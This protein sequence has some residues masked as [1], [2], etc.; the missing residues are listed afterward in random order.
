MADE[1]CRSAVLL[2]CGIPASGKSTF[3]RKLQQYVHKTKGDTIHTIRVCYDD[4]IPSDLDVNQL[5]NDLEEAPGDKNSVEKSEESSLDGSSNPSKYSLWKQFR[6]RTLEAVEKLVD[7]IENN[8]YKVEADSSD[9]EE[10]EMEGLPTFQEFWDIFVKNISTEERRC[11]CITSKDWRWNGSSHV[12]LVDDNMFYHSMRYEYVQLARKYRAGFAEVFLNCPLEIA[13][14]RNSLRSHPVVPNTMRNMFSKMEPPEAEKFPWEQYN[15]VIKAEEKPNIEIMD[16][17]I[18]LTIE[19]LKHPVLQNVEDVEEKEK[20][21]AACITSIVYQA[22]QVLRKYIAKVITEAK[23]SGKG[24]KELQSLASQLNREKKMF[25]ESLHNIKSHAECGNK[26]P[27]MVAPDVY[28]IADNT[29]S[30]VNKAFED[31]TLTRDSSTE[32][33]SMKSS[34]EL[35]FTVV[36]LEKTAHVEENDSQQSGGNLMGKGPH[37]GLHLCLQCF[38]SV[39]DK[40]TFRLFVE[41]LFKGTAYS[42]VLQAE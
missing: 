37:S 30:T 36:Q 23:G 18:H 34:K 35:P 26:I 40:E 33:T 42:Q 17:V 29:V 13:E 3:A 24:K 9:V 27:R 2:I 22:D 39:E 38:P 10:L 14:K 6:K 15:L 21:R 12:I 31:V 19:A 20:S 11:S 41:E 32:R 1:S 25:L 5:Q 16:S 4:L 28:C 7:M 8:L